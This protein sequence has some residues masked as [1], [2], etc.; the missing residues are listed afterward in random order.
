MMYVTANFKATS[1]LNRV[2]LSLVV[3]ADS[4]IICII[5][6]VLNV[7]MYYSLFYFRYPQV[8]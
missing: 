5:C 6:H 1:S 8:P 4:C 3:L 2:Y 7:Y